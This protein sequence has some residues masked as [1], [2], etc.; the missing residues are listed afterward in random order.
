MVFIVEFADGRKT[1]IVASFAWEA[2]TLAVTKFK[3]Q[4]VRAVRQAGLLDMAYRR[5][6][7]QTQKVFN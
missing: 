4:L 2:R 6:A 7:R 5:P 1:Q 3:G